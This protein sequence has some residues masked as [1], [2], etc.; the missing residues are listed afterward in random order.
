MI[1]QSTRE[2]GINRGMED[3][4]ALTMRSLNDLYA[5]FV[6][7]L[8]AIFAGMI[9]IASFW[10][11]GKVTKMIFLRAS[12]RTGLDDRLRLLFSR[13]LSIGIVTVGILSALPIMI[14]NFSLGGMLAGLGFVSFIIGF[15][16]RDIFND[17]L[18]GVLILWNRPFGAGDYVFLKD[19]EGEVR[20]VG[21]RVTS[22]LKDDGETIR[23][24]N[25]EVYSNS[26]IVRSAG[27]KRRMSLKFAID[28]AASVAETKQLL[29]RILRNA[30]GVEDEP[31][32][33]VYVTDLGEQ[34]VNISVF[35]WIET[36]KNSPIVTFDS[37]ATEI[38][39]SL[40]KSGIVLFPAR[41]LI[42]ANQ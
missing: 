19:V 4:S 28:Y 40:T 26:L 7:Q 22:L 17:L 24:P 13:F 36:K 34:G 18:S 10:L 11:I 20:E 37:I 15:A 1:L 16:A 35:F 31:K 2:G 23:I 39:E 5:G 25:R 29:G 32:P 27:A 6:E 38:Q 30:K 3:V 41:K 14:P 9:I 33:A 42:L 21:M 12:R 8:P